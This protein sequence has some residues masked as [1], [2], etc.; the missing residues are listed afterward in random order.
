MKNLDIHMQNRYN[1]FAGA[2]LVLTLTGP[3]LLSILLH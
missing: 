2:T 1:I 3:T